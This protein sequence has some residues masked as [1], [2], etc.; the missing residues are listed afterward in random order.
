MKGLMIEEV[1][2][3]LKNE[4]QVPKILHRTLLTAGVGESFIA[5]R[6]QD[7]EEE[8]P[9]PFKLAYLP[10]FGMVRL[11]LT[12]IVNS[13]KEMDMIDILFTELKEKVRDVLIL[14]EDI[15]LEE[16]VGQILKQKEKTI[17]SAESC[18]GG[19]ISHLLTSIAGSSEY[20]KGTVVAYSYDAKENLLGVDNNTL[21]THGAVS[22]ETV[23]EMLTGLLK[24]TG[25]DYG[26]ATTGIMGPGGGTADKPVGT[27]WVAVGKKENIIAQCFHFRFDRLKNIQLTAANALLML[28]RFLEAEEA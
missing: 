9:H 1:L 17:A 18:S 25:A 8:L 7:W 11:R 4:L 21:L 5:E 6:L 26:I 12:G 15:K 2:P 23:N 19:Y 27:V 28:L 13:E 3:R 22:K 20:F 14:E 10:S 24:R 16:R